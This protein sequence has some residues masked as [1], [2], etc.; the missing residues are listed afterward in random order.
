MNNKFYIT[1][2]IYYV[3]AKPHLGTLYTTVL[4]DVIAR[5]NILRGKDVFFLT[6]TD[7]H[8]Q[9]IAAAAEKAGKTPQ[10]FVDGFIPDYKAMWKRYE[11]EYSRFIRTT[12]EYHVKA[13]Q[14]WLQK[15]IDQKDIYKSTY[16]GW[17]CTPCETFLTEKESGGVAKDSATKPLCPQCNRETQYI[18]EESYFFRLSAYQEKLLNFY[19]MHPDFIL[20]RERANEV[21]SFVESGL[22][23]LCISRTTITW[24]IPFPN[25]TKHVTY[26]WADA[27]NN[28]VTAIGYLQKGHEEEF[29]QWWPADVHVMGKDIVRFHAV[30][31]PAFLMA[32]GLEIPHH[33][34]V[35]GWIKVGDQKM[36]KSLGNAVD[37][38]E[39]CK[40]YGPDAVRYYLTTQLSVSQD[41]PFSVDELAQRIN[42]DLANEMGNLLNRMS[43]LAIK[44]GIVEVPAVVTWSKQSIELKKAA[45]KMLNDVAAY[46]DS[47]QLH[48]AYAELKRFVGAVNAYFHAREPW[49]QIKTDAAGFVETISATCHALQMIGMVYW[50][51]MPEKMTQLLAALGTTMILGQDL[52]GQLVAQEWNTS[53]VLTAVPPLFEKIEKKEEAL[54]Q[55]ETV[56]VEQ[57]LIEITDFGKIDLLVGTVQSAEEVPGS[58]KLI[59]TQVNCGQYGIKQVFAGVKKFYKPE[60]LVGKQ[61]VIVGNL[62]PRKIMG[63]ESQGMMLFAETADGKLSFVTPVQMAING[64]KLR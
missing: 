28:Y 44:Q 21:V 11:I 24:G 20:P 16:S 60:E 6:G 4:A 59:K 57:N 17:Y 48:L 25:D 32:S 49:K 38:E 8:G 42:S 41:S 61:V 46:Q 39:L 43:T 7:E 34:V 19:K 63:M 36:S 15:L 51:V 2:P 29:K 13:V 40:T 64:A 45:E 30:Y 52:F 56:V 3:T 53:F 55:E 26:V 33:L 62:K 9:K 31:W 37:P 35:H 14:Q 27:L 1:T 12:D 18:S 47:Y 5:W 54:V 22:K 58:D 23:D 10:A 50:P